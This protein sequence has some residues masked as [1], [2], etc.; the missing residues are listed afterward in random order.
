MPEPFYPDR[1]E[2]RPADISWK[3]PPLPSWLSYRLLRDSEEVTWVRG[4]RFSPSW[5]RF[6]THPA[7]FLVAL[8]LIGVC[9]TLGRALAGSWAALPLWPVLVSGAIFFG[10]IYVLAFFNGYFTRLIVTNYRLVIMQGYEVRRSWRIDDLPRSLVRFARRAD[11][12]EERRAVDIE[13]L[14]SMLS[15][16]SE[17]FAESKAIR[18]FGKQL[19]QIRARE[20]GRDEREY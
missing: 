9:L 19:D 16:G 20:R 7:L 12:G 5:E 2:P 11:T 10:S 15:A 6:V 18:A 8:A 3:F 13:A 14:Q 17:H 1:Y 4:P